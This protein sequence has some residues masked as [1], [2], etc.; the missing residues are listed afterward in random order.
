MS[1]ERRNVKRTNEPLKRVDLRIIVELMKNSRRSDREIAKVVGV[2]QPTVSRV[3]AR[4]EREGVIRE[5]TMIPDFVKL[6]YQ[7]MASTRFEAHRGSFEIESKASEEI[8]KKYGGLTAVEGV[9]EKRNRMFVNLYRD[10]SEYYQ[11][12]NYLHA[13]PNIDADEFDTFLV[14]L[15]KPGYRVLSMSAMANQLLKRINEE[16][17]KP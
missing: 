15:N 10:Y 8:A 5:Y 17:G 13:I 14:D 3:I 9:G 12:T 1:A 11:A 2:S 6:G 16:V 4:L 7:I